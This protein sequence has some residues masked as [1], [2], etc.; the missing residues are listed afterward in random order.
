MY[1]YSKEQLAFF[2][3][4]RMVRNEGLDYFVYG[5][6]YHYTSALGLVA[7]GLELT[8]SYSLSYIKSVYK[9]KGLPENVL[10]EWDEVKT[11]WIKLGGTAIMEEN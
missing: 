6:Y 3:K 4:V 10:K 9:L 2:E 1:K 5:D 11:E 8:F 7:K